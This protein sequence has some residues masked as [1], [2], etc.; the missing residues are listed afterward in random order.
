M[1][2]LISSGLVQLP[3]IYTAASVLCHSHSFTCSQR[4]ISSIHLHGRKRWKKMAKSMEKEGIWA[5]RITTI[6][7]I[8]VCVGGLDHTQ[9]THDKKGCQNYGETIFYWFNIYNIKWKYVIL[10]TRKVEGSKK[11]KTHMSIC[12]RF[13]MLLLCWWFFF[14]HP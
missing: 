1:F 9:N 11:E 13:W 4:S 14:F 10:Y 2:S 12:E 3:V 6:F 7:N 8:P 5:T